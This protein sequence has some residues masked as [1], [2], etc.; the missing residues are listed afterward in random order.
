MITNDEQVF[1]WWR[2]FADLCSSFNPACSSGS[3]A[4]KPHLAIADLDGQRFQ[5]LAGAGARDTDAVVNT[6][7]STVGGTLDELFLVVEELVR[8]P[9]QSDATMRT[10]VA[11]GNN[12]LTAS[13]Q[14][15]SGAILKI[16]PPRAV[17]L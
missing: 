17:E 9:L 11:P 5:L 2:F 1:I 10:A 12:T 4:R 7:Q 3:V 8:L 6:K 14:Q 15:Q 13:D 16:K